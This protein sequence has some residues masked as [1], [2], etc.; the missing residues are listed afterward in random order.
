M[1]TTTIAR[2]AGLGFITVIVST[3]FL[4]TALTASAQVTCTQLSYTLSLGS[5][6][7]TTANEVSKLQ[8]FLKGKGYFSDGITGYF[9]PAT[10]QAVRAWQNK[11]N[12]YESAG[13]GTIGATSRARISESCNLVTITQQSVKSTSNKFKLSGTA[14]GVNNVFVALVHPY[15]NEATDWHSTYRNGSYIAFTGDTITKVTK[16]KWSA[17]FAGIRA[18]TYEARV[19]NND[20]STQKLLATQPLE[21]SASERIAFKAGN[22]KEITLGVGQTATDGG[23]TVTLNDVFLTNGLYGTSRAT[24]VIHSNGFDPGSYSGG[25]GDYVPEG[26]GGISDT[27]AKNGSMRIKIK[28]IS[29]SMNTATFIVEA[30]KPKG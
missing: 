11:E 10:Q 6:D 3:V 29:Q 13:A 22:R 27:K 12:F 19:Y 9:G 28:S 21:V 24:F 30:G 14:Q 8:Q 17:E 15:T 4:S 23:V 7:R 26:G 2:T 16:G 5:S 20:D 25:I 1:N 18:G